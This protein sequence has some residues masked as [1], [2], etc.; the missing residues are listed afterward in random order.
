MKEVCITS[1][2]NQQNAFVVLQEY[3]STDTSRIEHALNTVPWTS[4]AMLN[5]RAT[6]FKKAI[7]ANGGTAEIIE[8]K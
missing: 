3:Y 6:A 4:A 5:D 8:S 1:W 7:V 2:G